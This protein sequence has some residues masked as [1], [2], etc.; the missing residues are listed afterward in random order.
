M[1][2]A[3]YGAAE[4]ACPYC[5]SRALKRL[6]DRVRF[7]KSED[8]RMEALES[9]F[10]SADALEGLEDDPR[11]MGALMRKMK[12]EMGDEMG[13][14]MGPEFDEVIDRLEKGQSPEEIEAAMPDLGD[15]MGG[16]G[17]GDGLEDF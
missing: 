2:Y 8:S 15:G 5:Q 10:G 17:G 14:E 16:G 12:H 9:S 4:V 13:D 6:I 11:A 7:Q 1:T 3:E